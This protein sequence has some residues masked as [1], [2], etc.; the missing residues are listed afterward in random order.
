S[1]R[2]AR[3]TADL[4]ERD[5]DALTDYASDFGGPLKVQV[6]GPWTLAASVDL[7]VGGRMLRDPGAVRDL[8]ASLAEGVVAHI[9]DLRARVPHAQLVLQLD[10]PSLPAILAGHVSTESGF[11]RL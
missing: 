3:R 5:M 9:A 11:S 1:G 8:T 4:W 6:A 2:D 7:P 10:E